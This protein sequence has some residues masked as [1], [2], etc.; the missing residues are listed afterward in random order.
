MITAGLCAALGLDGWS[1]Q[2]KIE[3]GEVSEEEIKKAEEKLKEGL[4]S[5]ELK[6]EMDKMSVEDAEAMGLI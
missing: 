4:K 2:H 5:N 3:N 1:C 6:K